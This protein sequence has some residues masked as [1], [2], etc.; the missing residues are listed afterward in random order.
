MK[1]MPKGATAKG[2]AK[3][4]KRSDLFEKTR[5]KRAGLA[6]SLKT[7]PLEEYEKNILALSDRRSKAI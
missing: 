2:L 5:E 4:K 3:A 1:V 7:V 6:A